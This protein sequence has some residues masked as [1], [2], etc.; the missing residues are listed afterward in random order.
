[1]VYKIYRTA[2]LALILLCIER[3]MMK[4]A[5]LYLCLVLTLPGLLA[6][7]AKNKSDDQNLIPAGSMGIG[8]VYGQ[9]L[10]KD[11]NKRGE[12]YILAFEV[13]AEGTPPEE[14]GTLGFKV[15]AIVESGQSIPV[16][17]GQYTTSNSEITFTYPDSS[18]STSKYVVT[19]TELTFDEEDVYVRFDPKKVPGGHLIGQ[20]IIDENSQI[21]HADTAVAITSGAKFGAQSSIPSSTAEFVPGEILVRYKSG[22]DKVKQTVLPE[23]GLYESQRFSKID[24]KRPLIKV[25]EKKKARFKDYVKREHKYRNDTLATIEEL[26]K[27]P[28]VKWAV[29]NSIFRLQSGGSDS[30]YGWHLNMIN[31]SGTQN[32]FNGTPVGDGDVIVA[33]LDTGIVA[34]PDLQANIIPGYDFVSSVSHAGD[35]NGIDS[36]AHDE[37][38]CA[39]LGQ[40]ENCNAAYSSF[41]GTFVAGLVAGKPNGEMKIS[42]TNPHA[43]IMPIRV[44]GRVDGSLAIDPDAGKLSDILNGIYYAAGIGHKIIVNGVEVDAPLPAQR[45]HIINMSLGGKGSAA[46][47]V[48]LEEAVDAAY[49]AGVVVIAAMGNASSGFCSQEDCSI[50]FYPAKLQNAWAVTA[51]ANDGTFAENYSRYG[52]HAFIAAPGGTG[53]ASPTLFSSIKPGSQIYGLTLPTLQ[54]D[55]TTP[56]GFKW[57][58][59]TSMSAPLVAGVVSLMMAA[60]P[61]LRDDENIAAD[62]ESI[63]VCLR[64][65]TIDEGEAGLD[66]YYGWGLIDPK[67]ALECIVPGLASDGPPALYTSAKAVNAGAFTDQAVFIAHNE[68]GGVITGIEVTPSTNN[69][70]GWLSVD[71]SKG[72]APAKIRVN[73]NREG[74]EAG[75]YT[76]KLVVGSSAGSQEISVTMQVIEGLS[77]DIGE[78]SE[79]IKELKKLIEEYGNEVYANTVDVGNVVVLLLDYATDN[80]KYG[81]TTNLENNY[82]FEFIG[83]EPG[84]YKMVAG[85]DFNGDGEICQDNEPCVEWPNSNEPL[86]IDVQDGTN[87]FD[88]FLIF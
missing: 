15:S 36:N 79:K 30:G 45:A 25:S 22:K 14:V 72:T 9:W 74:L 49:E 27:D 2:D 80:Y 21:T 50:P 75:E 52:D 10:A 63:R 7:E 86:A 23:H 41:H 18:T 62:M 61:E 16:V 88:F 84:T 11:L 44:L 35:G 24:L 58:Y 19:Q 42:G 54:F 48:P 83:I 6:C 87:I 67:S 56:V 1:V 43:K 8:G 29:P 28:N 40:L 77:A 68:G 3:D 69:G 78:L 60:K 33:V 32:L 47:M 53:A 81:L 4:K 73:V 71:V 55:D 17:A 57:D 70:G 82:I 34:H 85:I 20:I 76:G 59:G 64:S 39:A 31:W 5:L 66:P 65:T 37:G 13:P 46:E 51:I 26:R 38:D 12:R